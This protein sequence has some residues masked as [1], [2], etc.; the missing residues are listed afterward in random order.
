MIGQD[1]TGK[2]GEVEVCVERERKKEREKRRRTEKDVYTLEGGMDGE[3]E[4]EREREKREKE[5]KRERAREREREKARFWGICGCPRH[6]LAHE[7]WWLLILKWGMGLPLPLLLQSSPWV[8][9]FP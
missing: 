4:R 9:P 6:R 7:F 1:K 3:R 5:R 8:H 2:N